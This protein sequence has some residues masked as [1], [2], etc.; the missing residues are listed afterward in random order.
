MGELVFYNY[1]QMTLGNI[2]LVLS[3]KIF[4]QGE[5]TGRGWFLGCAEPE[6]E[7]LTLLESWDFPEGLA[8]FQPP[9]ELPSGRLCCTHFCRTCSSWKFVE[10]APRPR[11]SEAPRLRFLPAPPLKGGHF[12]LPWHGAPGE[13]VQ[14]ALGDPSDVQGTPPPHQSIQPGFELFL[15]LSRS[16]PSSLE[17]F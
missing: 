3:P 11:F 1:I 7:V 5:Q 2:P 14:P 6:T 4:L 15:P 13:S 12:P 9:L 10:E 16:L 8:W 17:H